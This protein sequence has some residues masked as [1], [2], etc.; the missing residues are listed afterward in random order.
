MKPP[1]PGDHGAGTDWSLAPVELVSCELLLPLRALEPPCFSKKL[2]PRK[3]TVHPKKV[4]R[5]GDS[6]CTLRS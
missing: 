2:V 3:L 1:G 4:L 5:E 6:G